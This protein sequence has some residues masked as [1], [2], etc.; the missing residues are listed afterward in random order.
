MIR[1]GVL[2]LILAGL[3]GVT[4]AQLPTL[5]QTSTAREVQRVR[6]Y[7]LGAGADPS[8]TLQ[9]GDTRVR[10]VSNALIGPR[11]D[12]ADV[13]YALQVNLAFP[14]GPP[15]TQEV[16]LTSHRSGVLRPGP[17]ACF[18]QDGTP[19]ADSRHVDIYLDKPAAPGTTITVHARG[20][21]PA[22]VRAWTW[23]RRDAPERALRLLT[24]YPELRDRVGASI[25]L[26]S[27]DHLPDAERRALT[28]SRFARLAAAGRPGVGYVDHDFY[29]R[30]V[31]HPDPAVI[32]APLDLSRPITWL[33]TG[34]TVARVRLAADPLSPPVEVRLSRMAGESVALASGTLLPSAPVTEWSAEIPA[35]TWTLVLEAPAG[36]KVSAEVRAPG[37]AVLPPEAAAEV[38]VEP[39]EDLLRATPIGPD[40]PAIFDAAV[41]ADP[42]SRT[43]EIEVWGR[44]AAA[45]SLTITT[46]TAQGQ[47]VETITPA[48]DEN[49]FDLALTPEPQPL[50]GPARLLLL[51]P[52]DA[53][54]VE[55]AA[56]TPALVRFRVPFHPATDLD[57][58]D[59]PPVVREIG[60]DTTPARRAWARPI[61]PTTE[62][63]VVVK[64]R[65]EPIPPP[66]PVPPTFVATSL[67][68]TGP[69]TRFEA[70]ERLTGALTGRLLTEVPAD[71]P[72]RVQTSAAGLS[73]AR[74]SYEVEDRSL[75]GTTLP[76]FVDGQDGGTLRAALTRGT[77]RIPPLSP[78]VHELRA[79]PPPGL[80][81]FVNLPPAPGDPAPSYRARSV[82]RFGRAPIELSVITT[83]RGPRALNIV[84]YD[85]APGPRPSLTLRATIDGGAPRRRREGI[86][87]RATPPS[88]T[89]L[90]PAANSPTVARLVDGARQAIGLPRTLLL[91][92][93]DDLQPGRHTIR[94]TAS[95]EI[96]ARFFVMA[97][98]G[99]SVSS[100]DAPPLQLQLGMSDE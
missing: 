47:N 55:V 63:P 41:P 81:L 53:R 13:P 65:I 56:S 26:G 43:L 58:S 19:I 11:T 20:E 79:S 36:G 68:P 2:I 31:A 34:P 45:P 54:E 7:R 66:P 96:Y 52:S 61:S 99:A 86:Y 80:R 12:G 1:L 69:V 95:Q 33:L 29:T 37:S 40:A 57:T 89:W 77:V 100:A 82:W 90:L 4:I 83:Q 74:W 22:L 28:D 35:G 76:L 91:P 16:H 5:Q 46:R 27:W 49:R 24:L 50:W 14:N 15:Q 92:L 88:R 8:F 97:P 94:I 78:G 67:N 39:A 75:L 60:L 85:P 48:L 84:V 44:E 93:G 3:A 73:Q 51:L 25:G 72:L 10:I 23:L 59:G 98:P 70:L 18:D 30:K 17:D 62:I 21:I 32:S 64:G 9:G 38:E 6:G 71:R 87:T 42:E